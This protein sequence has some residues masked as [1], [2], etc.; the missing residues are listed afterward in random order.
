MGEIIGGA[1]NPLEDDPV[2]KV[3]A[4]AAKA[5]DEDLNWM[6]DFHEGRSDPARVDILKAERDKRAREKKEKED[7]KREEEEKKKKEEEN[8]KRPPPDTNR[9]DPPQPPPGTP[10][11]QYTHDQVVKAMSIQDGHANHNTLYTAGAAFETVAT[12][13]IDLGARMSKSLTDFV[14]KDGAWEGPAARAFH[15]VGQSISKFATDTGTT[16][17][18][19]STKALMESNGESLLVNHNSLIGW[20]DFAREEVRT[21]WDATPLVGKTQ[22]YSD[23]L[24][25]W[26]HDTMNLAAR[27]KIQFVA[28]S[29]EQSGT[30]LRPVPAQPDPAQPDPQDIPKPPNNAENEPPETDPPPGG[31]PNPPGGPGGAEPPGGPE[32]LEPPGGPEG[33]EPPGGPEG[34]EP[35]GPPGDGLT[36]PPGL[37]GD[38][39]DTDG[40]GLPDGL[41][42]D[43][44]GRIDAPLPPDLQD[45]TQFA[46]IT[47]PPG[48]TGPRP[49]GLDLPNTP[50]PPNLSGP[51]GPGGGTPPAFVPTPAPVFTPP[52]KPDGL[53]LPGGP[54]IKPPGGP[55]V[56][57]LDRFQRPGGL[58]NLRGG[59]VPG[60]L[61]TGRGLGGTLTGGTLTGPDRPGG[62]GGRPDLPGGL[63]GGRGPGGAGGPGGMMPPMH[64]GGAGGG[65]GQQNQDRE[66]NTWLM[67]DEDVWENT[68]DIPPSVLGRPDPD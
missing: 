21:K 14:G 4:D 23:Q 38:P 57:G 43:G 17:Q 29:Y 36:A 9:Q 39:I 51:N 48:L 1:P 2:E 28:T 34:L 8:A 3:A 22:Q 56:P 12:G 63:G 20:Y 15:Q 66:R 26:Y 33:L 30:Q 44:D 35:P 41:D 11:N 68:C 16:L 27:E 24:V 50:P 40:D 55:A 25:A 10:Y 67:E 5:S 49:P 64:P 46:G 47:P 65:G 32:G 31:G 62:L 19:P 42:T 13:L 54:G 53:R 52:P 59:G 58:D 6:I 37:G 18:N 60:G 61:T 45:K 7:K